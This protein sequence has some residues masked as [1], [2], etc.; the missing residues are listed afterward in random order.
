MYFQL[1]DYYSG[2][3]RY[4]Y[5]PVEITP[6]NFHKNKRDDSM[7]IVDNPALI[8]TVREEHLNYGKVNVY[9]PDYYDYGAF[10]NLCPCLYF[11][12]SKFS[13]YGDPYYF[14][15]IIITD[16]EL[17]SLI[18]MRYPKEAKDPEFIDRALWDYHA[19]HDGMT[20][21]IKIDNPSPDLIKLFNSSSSDAGQ[22]R[23]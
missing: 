16:D 7:L 3:P 10:G 5:V 11:P 18:R 12:I 17:L 23:L 1:P 4:R 20:A 13:G 21:H 15:D 14:S 6:Q 2:P 22:N 8:A 9:V 19:E